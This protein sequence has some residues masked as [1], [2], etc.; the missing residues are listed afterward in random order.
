MVALNLD[1]SDTRRIAENCFR[2][3]R[4]LINPLIDWDDDF[5]WW[6]IKHENI[7]INPRY[8]KKGVCRVGC[9]GCPMAGDERWKQFEEFPTYKAAY[10]RAFDKM[11]KE[12]EK[13]GWQIGRHGVTAYMF[14]NGGCRTRTW[15]VNL[16]LGKIWRFTKRTPTI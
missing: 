6:Y 4:V 12:R 2:T 3:H 10:I 11:L 9:I 16:H 14:L 7:Y 8:K 1:N 5:L 15:T 13:E